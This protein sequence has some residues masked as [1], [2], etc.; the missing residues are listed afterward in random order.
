MNT[1]NEAKDKAS[2]ILQDCLRNNK[3]V[4]IVCDSNLSHCDLVPLNLIAWDE[5]IKYKSFHELDP[6]GI[7]IV[8]K[9]NRLELWFKSDPIFI[10]HNKYQ[11]SV[12]EKAYQLKSV[13]LNALKYESFLELQLDET[14]TWMWQ[15]II[16]SQLPKDPNR[17]FLQYDLDLDN[18]SEPKNILILYK[19]VKHFSE[20][21][22]SSDKAFTKAL[23]LLDQLIKAYVFNAQIEFKKIDEKWP[24]IELLETPLN[25]KTLV[26]KPN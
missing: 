15:N 9:Y 7:L 21:F 12:K 20:E 5:K 6:R 25:E 3:K 14:K 16:D 22:S 13:Q 23:I 26:E 1:A 11:M 18:K 8:E 2:K 10:E 24:W 17:N 19:G 4:D